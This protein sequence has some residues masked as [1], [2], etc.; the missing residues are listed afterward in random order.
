ML[1][2]YARPVQE[3]AQPFGTDLRESQ[4][5]DQ[6]ILQLGH[7]PLGERQ[8]DIGRTLLGYS[9]QSLKLR[10]IDLAGPSF[11]VGSP[12][13]AAKAEA[14]ELLNSA[15]GSFLGTSQLLGCSE[16]ALF[17]A[18]QSNDAIPLGDPNWQFASTQFGLQQYS[19]ATTES[20]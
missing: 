2:R 12:F 4:S 5:F 18:K 8:P 1:P 6:I 19:F 16:H 10:P 13:K 9:N 15:I 14:I 11:R 7:G 3:S 17:D 20:T